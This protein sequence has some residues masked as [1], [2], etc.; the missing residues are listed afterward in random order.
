MKRITKILGVAAAIAVAGTVG[1]HAVAQTPMGGG[2][3]S[4]MGPGMMMGGHGPMAGHVDTAAHLAALKTELGITAQQ[5]PAWDAYAK[6]LA[7]IAASMKTQHQGMD[8]TAMHSMSDQDRQARMTQMRDQH[9]KAFQTVKVAAEK[10]LVA[11]DDAQKAKAKD[12][13]P[14]L[15]EHGPGTMRHAGMGGHSMGKH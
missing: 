10:L 7:D 8:M 4:G 2:H 12:I 14:G 15:A 3:G 9:D 6:S 11:L 13:L 1:W 5:Q